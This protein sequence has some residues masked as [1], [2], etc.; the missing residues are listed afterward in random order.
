MKSEFAAGEVILSEEKDE[1]FSV[2]NSDETHVYGMWNTPIAV[3]GKLEPVEIVTQKELKSLFR[4][5][6]Y[7]EYLNKRGIK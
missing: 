6:T 5:T 2:T 1:F 4:K 3:L 7:A